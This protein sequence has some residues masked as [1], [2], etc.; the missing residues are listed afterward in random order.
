ML[1]K[2][3]ESLDYQQTASQQIKRKLMSQNSEKLFKRL[4]K[5]K[6]GRSIVKD[7]CR[8]LIFGCQKKLITVQLIK[9]I[10]SGIAIVIIIPQN[11]VCV[12]LNPMRLHSRKRVKYVSFTIRSMHKEQHYQYSLWITVIE[13]INQAE[14]LFSEKSKFCLQPFTKWPYI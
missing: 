3:L 12:R 1:R 2:E 4:D 11:I 9:Y 10:L 8:I 7:F 14:C 6:G 5:Y 13:L